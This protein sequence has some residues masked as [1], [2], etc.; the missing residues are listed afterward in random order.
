MSQRSDVDWFAGGKTGAT[1]ARH[2]TGRLPVRIWSRKTTSPFSGVGALCAVAPSTPEDFG[3][4]PLLPR[5]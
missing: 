1:S 4:S 2:K 3:S 5:Y